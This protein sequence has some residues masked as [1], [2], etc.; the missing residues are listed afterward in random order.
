MRS[1]VALLALVGCSVAAE[2]APDPFPGTTERAPAAPQ[3]FAVPRPPLSARIFPCM[4][5]HAERKPDPTPRKLEDEHDEIR[6]NHGSQDRWC[7]DCHEVS[8]R[9]MLHL[10]GG[11]LIPMTES[12]RLCGQCHGDKFRDWKVGVHGKRTG[13]WSGQKQYLLCVHCHDPHVP[14]FKPLAPL[15]PPRRPEAIR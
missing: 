12:Y 9:D 14:R 13:S 6:L 8:N 1:C 3:E 15:P 7:F 11:Q 4:D 10:A 2:P 5:C